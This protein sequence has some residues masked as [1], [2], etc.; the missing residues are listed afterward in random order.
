[1]LLRVAEKDQ[2]SS[3]NSPKYPGLLLRNVFKLLY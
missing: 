1:M 2:I 3:A